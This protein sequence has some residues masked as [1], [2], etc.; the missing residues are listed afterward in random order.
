[1][2]ILFSN[3]EWKADHDEFVAAEKKSLVGGLNGARLL[4]VALVN[5]PLARKQVDRRVCIDGNV[6]QPAREL[7]HHQGS[8]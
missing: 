2:G 4:R 5:R 8:N 1:M 3:E 6:S 7:M